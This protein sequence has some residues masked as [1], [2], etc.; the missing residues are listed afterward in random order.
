MLNNYY[1]AYVNDIIKL[2]KT[3]VIKSEISA[4]L[5]NERLRLV[6]GS[7]SV[8]DNDKT[9]WKYYMNICGDY[10]PTDSMIFV[11]SLD[12]L[13]IIPFTKSSFLIHT[14]TF[15][16]YQF[17]SRFYN[18]LVSRYPDQESLILGV[19]NPADMTTAVNAADGTIL[20]YNKA[21]VQSNE[22]TL[23]SSIEEWIKN[24][25]VRWNVSSF[26]TSDNY[27]AAAVYAQMSVQLVAVIM[28]ERLKRCRTPEAHI[29]HVYHYLESHQKLHEF[30]DYMTDDQI[31]YF[32]KNIA[33]LERN[34]GK[35]KNLNKLIQ[36][37]MSVRR[38]PMSSFTVRQTTLDQLDNIKPTIVFKR[39]IFDPAFEN[40][41]LIEYNDTSIQTL[42]SDIAIDNDAYYV[43]HGDK[44]KSQYEYSLSSVIGTKMLESSIYDKTDNSREDIMINEWL[45]LSCCN[46][47]GQ[48]ITSSTPAANAFA[49]LDYNVSFTNPINAQSYMLSVKDAYIYAMYCYGKAVGL[50]MSYIPEFVC[51]KVANLVKPTAADLYALVD[52]YYIEDTVPP[53]IVGTM[54]SLTIPITTVAD[55]KTYCDSVNTASK[56]YD[57][58]V[59]L[60]EH[61][62]R[63]SMVRNMTSHMFVDKFIALD[64]S[65]NGGVTTAYTTWLRARDL[66]VVDYEAN[67][68]MQIYTTLLLSAI[69]LELN[70]ETLLRKTHRAMC[71]VMSRLNS[72]SVQLL[73]AS[74]TGKQIRPT[75]SIV[76]VGDVMSKSKSRVFVV[77]PL[78]PLLGF[79]A[80]FKVKWD[81]LADRALA[82]LKLKSTMKPLW[83]HIFA[84]GYKS[85]TGQ[86]I[87]GKFKIPIGMT[88]KT[89][90]P[91]SNPTSYNNSIMTGIEYF[92]ALTST[93]QN[94]LFDIYHK[95]NP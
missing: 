40:S 83:K 44:I 69:G 28:N 48:T 74:A 5:I 90:T 63:V 51:K 7:S 23:I 29:F 38:F 59:S 55:F 6:Y 92:D 57:N 53:Q 67:D 84:I 11:T 89:S 45:Y 46:S 25:L 70:E 3:L 21:Y 73:S 77:A 9:T 15:N 58:L 20:S 41:T 61:H 75:W 34:A 12:D 66:P 95:N 62:K 87:V 27:Y 10:H 79:N 72:Y 93:Q 19:L 17:G 37:I 50:N 16:A 14:A 30:M 32:Y 42:Q 91:L 86:V 82:N 49:M 31:M 35:N 78:D 54:P 52:Q 33:Y 8:D 47:L 71:K 64:E 80:K 4:L 76:R 56:A 68:Y 94:S 88:I 26:I 22:M 36:H 60:Q 43:E 13:S 2:A 81:V 65:P 1:D 39:K 18:D 85:N 24:Y